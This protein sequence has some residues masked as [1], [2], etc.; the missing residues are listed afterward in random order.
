MKEKTEENK[1]TKTLGEL[2]LNLPIFTGSDDRSFSFKDWDMETEE[3]L[4]DLQSKSKNVGEFVRQMMNL[5]LDE[6]QGKDW[7]SYLEE[8]K[9]VTLSKLH[10]PNMMY[11]YVALRVEEL[12]HELAFDSITCP[13][14][15]KQIRDF[16]ADLRTLD[17]IMKDSEEDL[18]RDYE[19]KKPLLLGNQTITGLKVGV[20]KWGALESV[21]AEKASNGASVKKALFESSISG[22]TN[23]SEDIEGMIDFKTLIKKIK[24]IDIEKISKLITENNGGPDMI[25]GGQCPH[26]QS[27]FVKPVDW[28]YEIFFDSSSL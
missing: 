11:M 2:G 3:K 24:K 10:F 7:E 14:C 17:I 23:N 18:V 26:C 5:L 25:V 6:F 20:T 28:G 13:S 22:A 9:I 19:L 21:P 4:S 12:G 1:N 27:D 16:R 8:E 15:A